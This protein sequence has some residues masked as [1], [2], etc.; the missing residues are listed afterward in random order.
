M[1]KKQI[2][3]YKVAKSRTGGGPSPKPLSDLVQRI[4]D[5]LPTQFDRIPNTFDDD[6]SI[7][8]ENGTVTPATPT[9]SLLPPTMSVSS[10]PT[11]SSSSHTQAVHPGGDTASDTIVPEYSRTSSPK[12]RKLRNISFES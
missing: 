3:D 6:E 5:L 4:W 12:K 2:S 10:P 11:T 9:A 8:E 7:N 1:A